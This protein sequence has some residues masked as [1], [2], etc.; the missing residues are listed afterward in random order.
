MREVN[1]GLG[2]GLAT[3]FEMVVTPLI[4]GFLGFLVDRWLGTKPI[5]M[6]VFALFVFG[7]MIWKLV[8]KYN[9]D[10]DQ[11]LDQRR[12]ESALRKEQRDA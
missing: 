2:D 6:L 4:F 1:T 10:L 3:A 11:A 9:T 12:S 5:F 8:N 7:Y